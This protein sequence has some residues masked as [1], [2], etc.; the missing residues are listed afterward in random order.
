MRHRFII[1][2][3]AVAGVFFIGAGIHQLKSCHSHRDAFERHVADICV[4]AA[5]RSCDKSAN[6]GNSQ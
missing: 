3:F 4:E 1:G 2:F 6:A 5:R